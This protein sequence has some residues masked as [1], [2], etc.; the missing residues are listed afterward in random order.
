MCK[1]AVWKMNN[2]CG[3][4]R[5]SHGSD[6]GGFG[7]WSFTWLVLSVLFPKCLRHQKNCSRCPHLGVPWLTECK[8][9]KFPLSHLHYLRTSWVLSLWED[10]KRKERWLVP[11]YVCMD[12]CDLREGRRAVLGWAST[13]CAP[14]W[15]VPVQACPRDP[16]FQCSSISLCQ[17]YL[18]IV[19]QAWLN[20][21]VEDRWF[22]FSLW[23][24]MQVKSVLALFTQILPVTI[25]FS[26]SPFCPYSPF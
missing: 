6:F 3:E 17:Y 25:K 8:L 15:R 11:L 20:C 22:L 19:R 7:D 10:T 9:A 13:V 14:L 1:C 18:I 23:A 4:E 21:T 12:G 5:E 24:I 26:S 2:V 16:S